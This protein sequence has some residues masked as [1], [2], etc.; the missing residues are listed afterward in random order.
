MK[1]WNKNVFGNIHKLVD[2]QGP[3]CDIHQKILNVSPY[4]L[5][6]LLTHEVKIKDPLNFVVD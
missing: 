5:D 2:N 1:E 6:A 4:D 3:C